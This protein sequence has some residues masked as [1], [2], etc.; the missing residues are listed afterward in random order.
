MGRFLADQIGPGRQRLPQLDCGRADRLERSGVV[1]D[2]RLERAKPCDP[3]KPPNLCRGTRI[4]LYP[5]QG[6]VTAKR[7]AP[8]Q[9]AEDMG[10]RTGQIFQPE[11]IAT[12]PP[13]IG[14]TLVRAKPALRI[15]PSNSGIGGKRRIDS[16]R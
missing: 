1:G 4:T 12:S 3:A 16:I 13:S 11:W 14:S 8:A 2:T 15:I 7:S 9:Q 5:A 6:T 10:R